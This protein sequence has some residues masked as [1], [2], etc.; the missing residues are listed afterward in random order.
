MT[1]GMILSEKGEQASFMVC[2]CGLSAK[3]VCQVWNRNIKS[4]NIIFSLKEQQK[5]HFVY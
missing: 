1:K 2:F 3:P 5:H 4:L